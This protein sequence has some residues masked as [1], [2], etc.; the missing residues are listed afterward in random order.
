[1]NS[2]TTYKVGLGVQV[3]LDWNRTGENQS[4]ASPKT[5]RRLLFQNLETEMNP[6]CT[7]LPSANSIQPGVQVTLD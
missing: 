3:T 7:N 1:M 2:I 5:H 4:F 6:E